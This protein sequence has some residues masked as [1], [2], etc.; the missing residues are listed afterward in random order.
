M[1]RSKVSAS[2]LC[3]GRIGISPRISGISRSPAAAKVKR[4]LR[5]AD[6]LG[7]GDLAV[8]RAVIGPALL[9]QQRMAE[10]D[11]LGRDRRA[12]GEARL[13]AQMEGDGAAVLRHLDA[14]R[15]QAVE[16]EGLVAAARQQALVD[17]VA[18][19]ARGHALDD[20]GVEAVEG[21]ERAQHQPAAFGRGRD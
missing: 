18:Q 10:E 1:V 6:L 17:V 20:E 5:G 3:R 9:L 2:S 16:R 13:R 15:D 21:A 7:L 12:V 19:V 8:V 4:T 14:F 11:V